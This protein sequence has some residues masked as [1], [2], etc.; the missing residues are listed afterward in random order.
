MNKSKGKILFAGG[1]TGG[2][3]YPALATIEMLQKLGDFKFLYVGAYGGIEKNIIAQEKLPFKE[4]WISGFQRY[5]TFRNI[6]F[7]LKLLVSLVQSRKIIKSFKPQ[8]VIGTG[9]YVSGPVVYTAAKM[10]IPCAIQ[11]QDSHPGITTR[12]LSKYVDLI[13]V[14]NSEV[15]RHLKKHKEKIF[16]SGNPVRSSLKI[17][18]KVKAFEFWGFNPEVP[19]I[20]VFGGSQGAQSINQAFLAILPKLL[21]DR[22]LQIIWQVGFNNYSEMNSYAIAQLPNVKVVPY[23]NKMN[24]AYSTADIIISRAGAITLAELSQAKKPCILIPYPLAAANHQEINARII[25]KKGAASVVIE[26]NGFQNIL[27]EKINLLLD[28]TNLIEEMRKKWD[29]FSRSDAS[30]KIAKRIINLLDVIPQ[31]N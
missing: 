28:D 14:P 21:K 10:K 27:L 2:H 22:K 20:L 26:K 1:G 12:L 23:I 5:F 6:L 4:I 19:V 15:I 31:K 8:V 16:V 3:I 9:G 29:K 24:L 25:E 30:E 13:F 11:E 17:I 18:D 7:P